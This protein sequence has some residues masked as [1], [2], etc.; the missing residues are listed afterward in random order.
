LALLGEPGSTP[1]LRLGLGLPILLLAVLVAGRSLARQIADPDLLRDAIA[2]FALMTAATYL[3]VTL[4]LPSPAPLWFVFRASRMLTASGVLYCLLAE[5]T[6]L[7]ARERRHSEELLRLGVLGILVTSS[8]D[9]DRVLQSAVD[10]SWSLLRAGGGRGALY[11][12]SSE[13]LELRATA[14]AAAPLKGT[15]V[16]LGESLMGKAILENRPGIYADIRREP[17]AYLLAGERL[18]PVSAIVAP[19]AVQ[20]RV[21]GA[22]A[23]YRE[24][25]A[26]PGFSS[27]DL[28]LLIRFA[29]QAAVAIANAQLYDET[30]RMTAA[31]EQR[32]RELAESGERHR[33]LAENAQDAIITADEEGRILLFN[34]KAEEIFGYGRQEVWGKNVTLLMPAEAIGRHREGL[35]RYRATG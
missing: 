23:V 21:L 13:T 24:A 33:L 18:H 34:R 30:Q 17:G 5:H 19:L 28:D 12:P 16:P 15:R 4:P 6:A 9:V 25:P 11:D 22:I 10:G 20:G 35:A 8:L 27:A 3:A 1:L 31:L 2:F 32:T 14:G 7:L 29:N 26:A